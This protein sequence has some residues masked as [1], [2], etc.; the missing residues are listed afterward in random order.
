MVHNGIEYADMQLIAE[1]YDLLRAGLGATPAEIAD[2]FRTWNE[3]DL[4][5]FLIQIT[6]QVL[7]HPDPETGKPFVDIVLD[8][9]EQ[10][11]TGRWTVQNALDLGIPITGIAEATF[12]RALSGH[13]DQRA[14][15]R[16]AFGSSVSPQIDDRDGFVEDVRRALYASKVVAY[17]QGFDHIGAGSEEYGWGIDRG[18]MATIWRGGCIIRAKFLNRIKEAFDEDPNLAS[19]IAAPYFRSAV[20]A[21]IDSWRRVVSTGAQLGIPTPG[22]SSALSYYDGLR[23][24]RLPAALTQGLRDFFGAHTYGRIDEDPDKRFHTLW[25]GDRTE[26]PA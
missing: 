5:S 9:A 23:T 24:E 17:A 16:E 1:A 3:G 2:I 4:D 19:L 12:A 7:A 26:V 13:A 6:A 25:S 14:A 8:Q 21:A 15:A 11:G 10:K 18:M 22:F 20:E